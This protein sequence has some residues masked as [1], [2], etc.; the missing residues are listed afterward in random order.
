[1]DALLLAFFFT[2][3]CGHYPV[4]QPIREVRLNAGYRAATMKT[5]K[6]SGSLLLFLTFS[7]GGM[8]A[9]ALSYGVLE[10]LR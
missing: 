3:G 10:E 5:P 1:M 2:V 9:A 6:N 8:R 4:N 7:G